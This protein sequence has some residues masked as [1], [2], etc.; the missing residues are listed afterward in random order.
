MA[1]KRRTVFVFWFA[2]FRGVS[3]RLTI[4]ACVDVQKTGNAIR[5]LGRLATL[6]ASRKNNNAGTSQTNSPRPSIS[7]APFTA[8]VID[9]RM[10]SVHEEC[11]D[12]KTKLKDPR[13][14]NER[15]DSGFSECSNCSTPSASCVCNLTLLDKNQ[16][17]IEEQSSSSNE[18]EDTKTED[19]KTA[20]DLSGTVS[21]DQDIRSEVSSLKY[22]EASKSPCMDEENVVA[23]LKVPARSE[24]FK[25][26]RG[27]IERRK[28][29]LI[30]TAKK[31][32]SLKHE[33]SLEKL[34]KSNKVAMLMEKF[35]TSSAPSYKVKSVVTNGA[36]RDFR[37]NSMTTIDCN[38]ACDVP[39]QKSVDSTNTFRS[40]SYF[41]AN[42]KSPTRNSTSPTTFRLSNKVRE[43]TERLSRPKQP[44]LIDDSTNQTARFGSDREA[45]RVMQPE[46]LKH[47]SNTKN[48]CFHSKLFESL[49]FPN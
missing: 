41:S 15:S 4:P 25:D 23:S 13:S 48:F 24:L 18:P 49:K 29:S 36:S 22:D 46:T 33:V 28:L 7:G 21:S 40:D 5:A 3:F 2:L 47:L 31:A 45:G 37:T 11:D 20:T 1:G 12:D 42:S 17:I 27:E 38:K 10:P 43:V 9:L 32:A 44:I 39:K 8:P 30:N 14:C 34:K 16:S 19:E 26:D 35:E 6:S